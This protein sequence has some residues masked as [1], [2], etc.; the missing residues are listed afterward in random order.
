MHSIEKSGF[1]FW[2]L[3]FR[4]AIKCKIQKKD[5]NA[6]SLFFVGGGGG[7]MQKKDLKAALKSSSLACAHIIIRHWRRLFK[8]TFLQILVQIS[9]WNSRESNLMDFLIEIQLEDP[10]FWSSKLIFR[11]C[12]KYKNLKPTF[13]N[14]ISKFSNQ[15]IL[16]SRWKSIIKLSNKAP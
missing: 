12:I 16:P 1:R 3:D 2:N 14:L 8:R 5:F 15:I 7:R 13:Q 4:P 11:S 6:C 10:F 9:Q